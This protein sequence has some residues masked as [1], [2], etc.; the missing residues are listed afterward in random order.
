[1]R[2]VSANTEDIDT[3][4]NASAEGGDEELEDGSVTVNNIVYSFRLNQ[5]QYD[6]KSYKKDLKRRWSNLT[7][8]HLFFFWPGIFPA[9]YVK[10]IKQ[11]L[12]SSG[13]STEE[14]QKW[15]GNM[16]KY[17]GK[18]LAKAMFPNWEFFIGESMDPKGM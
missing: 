16:M 15:E 5:T 7:P 13:S 2:P 1:M 9:A 18:V 8:F 3:G 4:A 10:Q 11:H 6:E 17:A 12:Q 14:I